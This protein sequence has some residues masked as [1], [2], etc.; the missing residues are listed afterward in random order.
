MQPTAARHPAGY[1]PAA[2]ITRSYTPSSSK[3]TRGSWSAPRGGRGGGGLG[4]C[5]PIRHLAH[6]P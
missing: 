1:F 5:T 4:Q 2:R 6:F 3:C